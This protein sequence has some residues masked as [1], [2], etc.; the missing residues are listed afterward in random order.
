MQPLIK[1]LQIKSNNLILTEITYMAKEKDLS[2]KKTLAD[3]QDPDEIIIREKETTED[4]SEE[5]SE[6]TRDRKSGV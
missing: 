6:V 5:V 4:Y 2:P 1:G 3:L